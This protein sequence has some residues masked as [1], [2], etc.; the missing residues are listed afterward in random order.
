MIDGPAF[1]ADL[2]QL[3]GIGT[4]RTGVHR[5]TYAADDMAARHWLMELLAACGLTPEIDGIGK[6]SN[7][8][9]DG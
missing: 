9:V 4:Y 6:L 5:P 8:F 2:D 3:R 1:L 7:R